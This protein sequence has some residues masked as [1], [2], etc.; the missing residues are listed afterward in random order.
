MKYFQNRKEYQ[1]AIRNFLK[2]QERY[3]YEFFD[4]NARY[5]ERW[6]GYDDLLEA[7][8]IK[9]FKGSKD[10]AETLQLKN[11]KLDF[12][13]SKTD[14]DYKKT[15]AD[16]AEYEKQIGGL[17]IDIGNIL[18]ENPDEEKRT[19]EQNASLKEKQDNLQVLQNQLKIF[20][21]ARATM[22]AGRKLNILMARAAQ[23]YK[24]KDAKV[25][26]KP[27]PAL[28]AENIRIN[29]E[30]ATLVD[31]KQFIYFTSAYGDL[32]QQMTEDAKA[33]IKN[34]D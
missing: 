11:I 15:L 27:N 23:A 33:G 3:Q 26:P 30:I 8:F 9:L 17:K 20:K 14:E 7:N 19:P 25:D 22:L 2:I 34:S 4:N 32:L 12:D 29:K 31:N 1:A 24:A 10:L 13:F 5:V 21:V 16:I 6:K 18:T 28:E